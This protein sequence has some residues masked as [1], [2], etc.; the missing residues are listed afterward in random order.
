MNQYTTGNLGPGATV[1]QGE[2]I[3]VGTAFPA[4]DYRGDVADLLNFY[5]KR[6][7]GR[8]A[9]FEHIDAALGQE[10]ARYLLVQALGGH[11]KSA[12]A[13]QLVLRNDSGRWPKRSHPSLAF[14]FIREER[15]ENNPQDFLKAVNSQLL[16]ILNYP[17]GVPVDFDAQRAQFVNLWRDA[18]TAATAERP[19]LLLVDGLDEMETER[20]TIANLLPSFLPSWRSTRM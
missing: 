8:E 9:V 12:L 18:A 4:I 7:V 17:G 14:F 6:F 13:A 15:A 3:N 19:L 11:G 5:S 2:N 1:I 20:I 10:G 16:H